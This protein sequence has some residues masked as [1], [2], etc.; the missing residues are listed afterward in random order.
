[1]QGTIKNMR[2]TNT[3][4]LLTVIICLVALT[5]T[6]VVW[7]LH[8]YTPGSLTITTTAGNYG[9]FID[10]LDSG[11]FSTTDA[12]VKKIIQAYLTNQDAKTDSDKYGYSLVY[13]YTNNVFI[14]EGLFSPTDRNSVSA[15]VMYDMKTGK[16]ISE[17]NILAKAGLYKDADLLLSV[18][19]L[20]NGK[21]GACLY[22]R[23][24][25][26]FTFIDL[27]SKLSS[28][29]ILFNDP[30]GRNLHAD[31]KGVDTQKKTFAMG[32]YDTTKKD[33]DGNYAY[34]RS[35]TISY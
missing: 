19:Y 18:S 28:T 29:E 9:L 20:D 5:C 6:F 3:K 1:M 17:C 31:I 32:V 24:T 27:T 30:A 22:E 14:T 25:P 33:A 16:P 13:Y 10:N 8:I 2:I 21:Q 23:G 11:Y 12:N 34:K 15:F 35:L 7:K 4:I 26:N